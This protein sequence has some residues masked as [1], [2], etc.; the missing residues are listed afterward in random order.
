MHFRICIVIALSCLTGC[1][2]TGQPAPS[3]VPRTMDHITVGV[4]DL[5]QAM[6]DFER[7]TSIAPRHAGRH[8]TRGSENALVSLGGK[9]YLELLGPDPQGIDT[10][11]RRQLQAFKRP[12]LMYWVATI[13]A[14]TPARDRLIASGIAMSEI[15][16]GMRK[17]NDGGEVRWRFSEA[18]P[19]ISGTPF[20][21]EWA[22]GTQHPSSEAAP[23]C[24]LAAFRIDAL[25]PLPTRRF[26][27]AL[28][29]RAV[30][31][32]APRP[33]FEARIRCGAAKPATPANERD[34]RRAGM[35]R[36]G[37]TGQ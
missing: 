18:A 6:A 26:I 19:A 2:S 23:G 33:G 37:A 17:T 8:L 32:A 34:D 16:N 10:P 5:R 14:L 20:L 21:I 31:E 29:D 28:G 4:P 22:P 15:G 7:S 36:R 3:A 11:L 9:Q 25:D 27:A 12:T 35:V 30:V 13:D 1:A 24:T